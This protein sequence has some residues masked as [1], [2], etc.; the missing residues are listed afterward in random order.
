MGKA[1][2]IKLFMRGIGPLLI[3]LD[4]SKPKTYCSLSSHDEGLMNESGYTQEKMK[5]ET[6]S[7]MAK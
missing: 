7:A 6:L 5:W 3:I 2:E 1:S 4:S